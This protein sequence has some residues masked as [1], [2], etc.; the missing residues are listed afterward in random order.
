MNNHS[1]IPRAPL[2]K[3][4]WWT[5]FWPLAVQPMLW[6]VEKIRRERKQWEQ[7]VKRIGAELEDGKA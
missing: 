1:I 3:R 4:I 7:A 6:R 5:V 2:W